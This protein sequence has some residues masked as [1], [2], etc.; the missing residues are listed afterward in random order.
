MDISLK[1]DEEGGGEREKMADVEMK[2]VVEERVQVTEKMT[3][4]KATS[5]ALIEK[6][7]QFSTPRLDGKIVN[8]LFLEGMM[9]L[10][11]THITRLDST[12]ESIE[13]NKCSLESKLKHALH[14]RDTENVEALKR[15][16][17]AMEILS[18]TTANHLWIQNAKFHTIVNHLFDLFLPNSQGNFNH[19]YRIFQHFIRRYPCDMLEFVIL[20]NDATI[21]F[22]SM[23]PYLTESP[24]MDSILSLIFIRDINPET[25]GQREKCHDK[26][27]QLK[28]LEWIIQAIQMT[29]ACQEFF[30][31]IIE[32]S[33][34]VENG[35]ILL[36]ALDADMIQ[37]LVKQIVD[38]PPCKIRKQT[39][40]I[41]KLLVKS[42]ILNSRA[43]STP[44]QGPLYLVSIRSQELLSNYLSQLSLLIIND[45]GQTC[46]TKEYPLTTSDIDLLE[47]VYQIL[48][49][50]NEKSQMLASIHADF[51]EILV[52]SFFEKSSSN[53]YHTLF[54]RMFS[55]ILTSNDELT[56]T[57]IISKP[58]L[59]QRLIQEYQDKSKRTDIRGYALLM[60]NHLRLMTDSQQSKMLTQMIMHH[61]GYQQFLPTL[62]NDTL[63]QLQHIYS[64]KLDACPRPPAHVGPS[65]PIQ[66][67]HFSPYAG[68][69]PLITNINDTEHDGIDLGSEFAYSLG[70]NSTGIEREEGFETP[71]E[72]LSRRNSDQSL[73]SSQSES[74][75]PVDILFESLTS[76]EPV[77]T[78]LKKKKKKKKNLVLVAIRFCWH[79][80]R[81]NLNGRCPACRR[82]YSE[83][84]AEFEPISADEI[85]RIR[86]EKKEKERQ[87][88]DME[89]A[90]RRHLA[91][92]RVVQKNLVYIIGLHPKLATEETIRSSD[93]FGQ[94]GKIAKIVINK[95]QIAPTSH[96][97]GAT[98][99]QPSAAVYVTFVRKEDATKAIYAVDG[100]VM[101]GRILR[102]SYGTTKY[103]T[104]YLRN[105]TCPN[106]NCLYLHE[107]GEDADTI[108]KEELATGK[109]RMRDQMSYDNNGHD[110]DDDDDY[111]RSSQYSSPSVSSSDFPPVSSYAHKKT[112]TIDDER[113]ALPASA[114]WG[115]TST[116]GTPTTNA[117][118]TLTPDAFGPPLSVAVAQQQKQQASPIVTKRKLEKKKRKELL[119]KQRKEE[120]HHQKTNGADIH[121]ELEEEDEDNE[122]EDDCS[123][124]GLVYFVLG[125]AFDEVCLPRLT[126]EEEPVGIAGLH[127]QTP[128]TP[129]PIEKLSI[130]DDDISPLEYLTQS[131]P[132]PQYT[133]TFNP[134]SHQI[135]RNNST[136]LFDSPVRKH[137][138]FGFAQF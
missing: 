6:L 19:F 38:N 75:P 128:I 61:T 56:I 103:C 119:Q 17:H 43:S 62:R 58:C 59:I 50:R 69:I 67:T 127:N 12:Q 125:N 112:T 110:D 37:V 123:F 30:I 114:S 71:S 73:S 49:N 52:N 34:Q 53:I 135:L 137:S 42:G 4:Y 35:D 9:E 22:D 13:L 134:F 84:I 14:T 36:K 28:F 2:D 95:R 130:K 29:K 55:L 117:D 82:E 3:D 31:R 1:S 63:T 99:M 70:F 26:L 66:V 97:N 126:K 79:H 60:L 107:P 108:S 100:S 5:I 138:R 16:Y 41:V 106:P 92:M 80:I 57:A 98:S 32:E 111:P 47:I 27:H 54:Y 74:G 132:T 90:N 85:Q 78:S 94:F 105:M 25:K 68:T 15:S 96:A 10:L 113:S 104:Y 23:L 120:G 115:K 72:Y 40:H 64:W 129:P 89:V 88:K 136:N 133:G 24:V 87:Q 131:V 81:E 46:N 91:S 65:P 102:A 118:R 77:T 21:L 48:F 44:V 8:V 116:P 7:L 124:D 20:S 11:M 122:T 93:Y 18:G 76:E 109:H 51:W 33:S 121:Q 39:I 86:R 83:Q 45:R 101:A